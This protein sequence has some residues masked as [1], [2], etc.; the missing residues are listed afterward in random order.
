LLSLID[1]RVIDRLEVVAP[2]G[3]SAR[4][5]VAK[6][7]AEIAATDSSSASVTFINSDDLS[8]TTA[9]LLAGFAQWYVR[10]GFNFEIGLTGSKMEAVAAA[11]ISSIC[12]VTQCWYVRPA[13]FDSARF[14]KGTGDMR[15]FRLTLN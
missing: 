5:R 4:N 14:T 2:D 1:G 10:K 13:K 7:I 3:N 11:A 6:Q 15:Y 8:K 12:K 9:F